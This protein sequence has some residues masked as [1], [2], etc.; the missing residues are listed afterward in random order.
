M[1]DLEGD[2]L[3]LRKVLQWAIFELALTFR[4]GNSVV[5]RY[6]SVGKLAGQM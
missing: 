4:F 5:P 1:L 3:C 2:L 6:L